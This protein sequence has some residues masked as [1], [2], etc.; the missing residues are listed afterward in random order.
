MT[1]PIWNTQVSFRANREILIGTLATHT[2]YLPVPSLPLLTRGHSGKMKKPDHV[3]NDSNFFQS[4]VF[5][6]EKPLLRA[7]A[8]CI[9]MTFLPERTGQEVGRSV[10]INIDSFHPLWNN[11]TIEKRIEMCS[12]YG[13]RCPVI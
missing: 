1:A 5:P 7:H 8:I 11:N 2:S 9:S 4:L 3:R 13:Q 12:T 10:A 6:F